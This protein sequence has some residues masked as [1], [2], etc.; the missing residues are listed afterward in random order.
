MQREPNSA[1]AWFDLGVKQQENERE[2]KA[3]LALKRAL[4]LDPSHLNAWLAIA[5]S[6]TN[7]NERSAADDAI[8]QWVRRNPNYKNVTEPFFEAVKALN[9][10]D[11]TL[12]G[13]GQ[14]RRHAELIDCLMTMARSGN[15]SGVVDADVQIA[16]AVL[17]NTS[18]DYKKAQDCFRAALAVRPDVSFV[19]ALDDNISFDCSFRTGNCTT[20]LARL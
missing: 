12:E 1:S 16:L 11:N 3:I 20:E 19:H 9:G 6:H 18:E 8:E 15:E 13:L 5:V 4:A 2:A 10:G 14:M 7:E 17:L